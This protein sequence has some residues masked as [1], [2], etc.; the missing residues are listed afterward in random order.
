VGSC[1]GTQTCMGVNGW[2]CTAQEPVLES[3]DYLD[4]DCDGEVDEDFKVD[5]KYVGLQSCGSCTQTCEGMIPHGTARCDGTRPVPLCVV[6]LCEDGYYASNEFQCLPVGEAYC[7]PCADD[8]VCEGGV[9]VDMG[10]GKFCT[11]AC[12]AD[13]CPAAFECVSQEGGA[14]SV[15]M[16][17]NGT[18]DCGP[19]NEGAQRPCSQTTG[20]A[21]CWGYELCDV[22]LGW[23]GCTAKEPGD[24]ICDGLDNDCNGIPDDGI[25]YTQPCESSNDH[26]TCSGVATCVGA[27]G[28]VCNAPTPG[29]EVCDY[30]DNN[31]DGAVDEGFLVDGKYST[32]HSCGS[33]TKDCSGALPNAVAFCDASGAVAECKVEQCQEGFYK[34]NDYQCI[35]PPDTR[36]K[37]CGTSAECYGNVCALIGSVGY[38]L[39]PCGEGGQCAEGHECQIRPEGSVCMPLSGS[40]DCSSAN[41]GNKR[42]CSLANQYGTCYGFETCTESGAWSTCDASEALPELCDGLDNNCNGLVD[43]GFGPTSACEKVNQWGE[44]PGTAVCMGSLGWI[45]QALEPAEELCDYIDNNCDGTVDEP[46]KVSGVYALDEHC[47][48][49]QNSCLTAIPNA[50]GICDSSGQ[51]PRCVVSKCNPG[52]VKVSPFQCIIPPD[53]TCQVCTTN[54]DCLGSTCLLLDGQNR[55]VNHCNFGTCPEGTVCTDL[56]TGTKYCLPDTGSCECSAMSNG[57]KRSCSQT[58]EYGICYGFESC[59]AG[60]GWTPCDARLPAME[61][62]D[63]VDN[64]CNGVS[65]D[66]LPATQPCESSNEHGTCQGN[67]TCMGAP[68]WVC[69]AQVPAQ[70]ECDYFDNDCDGEVDELFK[71]A[72]KY[73]SDEHCGACYNA[74]ASQIPNATAVCDGTLP[75]PRCVVDECE[76]GYIKVSP[77]QCAIPPDTT[78]LACN[79]DTEC[80]GS[81]C[82][83]VDGQKRCAIPCEEGSCQEGTVCTEVGESGSFCLPPSGSCECTVA[84]SGT[85]RSCSNGNEFGSCFGFETCNPASGWSPCDARVPAQEICDGIDNDCDGAADDGLP[86]TQPCSNSNSFGTCDGIATCVGASGWVCQAQ[87][88]AEEECDFVDNNCDGTVDEPFQDGGRYYTDQHCGSCFNDCAN[89]IPNAIGTCDDTYP[90]PRCVVAQCLDGYVKASPF[91]CVV[92]PDMTCQQCSS[93]ADCMGASCVTIDGKQRCAMPCPESGTCPAETQCSEYAPGQELCLPVTNSCECNAATNGAKRTCSN[94]NGVG[95]CYGL[96]TCNSSSGWSACTAMVPMLEICDGIDN[97]CDGPI[98]NDLPAT[99]PCSTSNGFGTCDGNAVCLGPAGWVC[100]APS[101]APE[102]CDYL[103]NDCDGDVD[104]DFKNLD[105]DYAAFGTCGSCSISCAVGFLNATA[106][107]DADMDPPRCVV[108]SCD[109]GYVKLNDYQCIPTITTLCE[110]CATDE[111]CLLAGSRCLDMS[112]GKYCGKACTQGSD[113]PSGYSCASFP[114]GSQCVPV[115]NTCSCSPANVGIGRDCSVTWPVEPA[116]GDPF[117]TCYGSQLCGATG[118]EQCVLPDEVCDNQDN[119]CNGIVDD[120]FVTGGKYTQDTNCGQ[121]G[122]NCLFLSYPFALARCDATLT[123]PSCTMECI[124]G[125]YDVNMN[126]GDGCECEWKSYDDMPDPAGEDSNCDGVDGELGNSIFVAK[127]GSDAN[128]GLTEDT[129]MLTIQAAMARAVEQGKRDIYVATGV[130]SQSITMV[131]GVRVYGGYSSDFQKRSKV[132]YETVIMGQTFSTQKPG[133]VNVVSITGAQDSTVLDGFTIFGKSNNTSGGSSYAVYIKDSTNAFTFSNNTVY[134]GNGGNGSAGTPGVSGPGGT[135]GDGNSGVNAFIIDTRNCTSDYVEPEAFGGIGG[136]R[137]CGTTA[138]HG[139]DGGDAGCPVGGTAP[140]SSENGSN[141]R[142]G[143]NPGG[144]GGSGGYDGTVTACSDGNASTCTTPSGG[145]FEGSDGAHGA[146]GAQGAA[147]AAGCTVAVAQSRE[148]S[149]SVGGFWTSNSGAAGGSGTHGAGGGGGGAGGGGDRTTSGC[150]DR[151]GASGGGGGAGGCA[152]TGGTGGTGGGGSFGVFLLFTSAP[153]S[154]PDFFG[155]TVESAN[156]GAGGPGGAGG[157]GGAGSAGGA[158]GLSVDSGGSNILCTR[159]GGTGGNGGQGGHGAGGGGGCGGASYAIFAH[160]VDPNALADYKDPGTNMLIQGSGGSGGA[161]GPSMGLNGGAGADG[162]AGAANF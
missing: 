150:T 6:D 50:E 14:G 113:C 37:P 69:Q 88:P 107:C 157:T 82:V 24:E 9:C 67:A 112:D 116:P 106:R 118:W 73:V 27:L 77:F 34:L 78:C 17:R 80:L 31:C 93:D 42:G 30:L 125:Y 53:M 140:A 145:Q 94:S 62:C 117:T 52:Y 40:C 4:N 46:F 162:A 70:E 51:Q 60:S 32:L 146:N 63:G 128:L 36:C 33:C 15:C 130:Y 49:C 61:L 103:D 1:T 23:V 47:G 154:V 13:Q 120:G 22:D 109:P 59:V 74:C 28:Y 127:N 20:E 91:Q 76:A 138:V 68:G 16:P 137:T 155:N 41:L 160:G 110:P 48:A 83:L 99:M 134:A 5:G 11:K 43:D 56:G 89:Q 133:A 129:P 135:S 111:N 101:A 72:G 158:G 81:K 87:A 143:S 115:S 12:E 10:F 39:V 159:R 75:V 124:G 142:L 19:G 64:D 104:E 66:G 7:R 8:G 54:A 126:P 100:Q 95:T 3:C 98:D 57:T 121:C 152:G 131:A 147:G 148:G 44:C 35:V 26:G 149:V 55:C 151:I 141:G 139:G 105:G 97:D 71:E 96:E 25:A 119:D 156:G 21:V 79:S 45:C 84:T 132:S 18:C 86:G 108:E 38:C 122:N 58:N 29:P 123:V 153:A 114:Q 85:K 65:D 136:A 92:P 144:T 90:V 2:M 161:G 102:A